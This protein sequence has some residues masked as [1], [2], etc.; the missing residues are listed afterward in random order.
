LDVLLGGGTGAV[1]LQVPVGLRGMRVSLG[2][3]A[4]KSSPTSCQVKLGWRFLSTAGSL[5]DNVQ[6]NTVEYKHLNFN[7][8]NL[9]CKGILH[10]AINTVVWLGFLMPGAIKYSASCD[11]NCEFKKS[12]FIEFSCVSII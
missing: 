9:E 2:S 8:E 6:C 12:Q 5:W 3:S 11:G 10:S 7:I 1:D 4:P